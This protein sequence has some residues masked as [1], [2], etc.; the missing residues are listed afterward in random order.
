MTIQLIWREKTTEKVH[1]YAWIQSQFS[2]VC[3]YLWCNGDPTFHKREIRK[4]VMYFFDKRCMYN[5]RSDT[6]SELCKTLQIFRNNTPGFPRLYVWRT[7]A[8]LHQNFPEPKVSRDL[9]KNTAS[10]GFQN[11]HKGP[12]RLRD[13]WEFCFSMYVYRS[14]LIYCVCTSWEWI[15]GGTSFICQNVTYLLCRT[16]VL[17]EEAIWTPHS[18]I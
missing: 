15:S 9:Q 2:H 5:V 7:C 4:D 17:Y 8:K 6:L 12:R 16:T 18:T 13:A 14:R 10:Q 3:T 1:M 11:Q